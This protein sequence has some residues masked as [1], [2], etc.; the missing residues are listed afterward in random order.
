MMFSRILWNY[1][2]ILSK[3]PGNLEKKLKILKNIKKSRNFDE[4]LEN[5]P[6]F[7]WR[8]DELQINRMFFIEKLENLTKYIIFSLKYLKFHENMISS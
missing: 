2:E 6:G 5:N 3:F 8:S 7:S 4:I 1:I